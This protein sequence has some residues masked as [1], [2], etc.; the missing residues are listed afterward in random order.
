MKVLQTN[1]PS[2]STI[3]Q[4]INKSDYSSL[5]TMKI[6]GL[7]DLRSLPKEAEKFI[8]KDLVQHTVLLLKHR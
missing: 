6:E 8:G 4:T 1:N 2:K 3:S 5:M 7:A